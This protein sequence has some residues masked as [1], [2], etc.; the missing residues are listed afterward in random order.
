L[1]IKNQ[2]RNEFL[3]QVNEI[4]NTWAKKYKIELEKIEGKETFYIKGYGKNG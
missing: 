1:K 4:I 2:S 3:T